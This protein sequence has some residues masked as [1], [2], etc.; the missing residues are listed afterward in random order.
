MCSTNEELS[1]DVDLAFYAN[2]QF[3]PYEVFLHANQLA[4]QLRKDKVVKE[5]VGDV[6][7]RRRSLFSK[8]I[9]EWQGF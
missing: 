3:D 9:L 2:Q 1:S 8:V 6:P 4:M 7:P 5:C